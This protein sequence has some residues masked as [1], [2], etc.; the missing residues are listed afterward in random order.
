MA[1]LNL[2]HKTEC[3]PSKAGDMPDRKQNNEPGGLT[4]S[5]RAEERRKRSLRIIRWSLGLPML[6]SYYLFGPIALAFVV[7]GAILIAVD[8]SA[9]VSGLFM[10]LIYPSRPAEPQPMYGIP[11]SRIANGLYDEAEQEYEK[12]IQEFPDEIKPHIDM[13]NIAVVRMNDAE[14]AEKLFQRGMSLIKDPAGKQALSESY[15]S[16]LTRLKTDENTRTTPI[17]A[18]KIK[19]T[20]DRIEQN[21]MKM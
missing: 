18:E 14:L 21:R 3:A 13:I 10:N 20:K 19:A 4:A 9:F 17:S 7:L 11:E 15:K 12:I 8:L 2:A 16:I 5:W 1:T 6:A